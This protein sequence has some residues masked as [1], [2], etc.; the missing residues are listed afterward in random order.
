[1]T[2]GALARDQQK[3]SCDTKLTYGNQWADRLPDAFKVYPRAM[4]REATGSDLSAKAM[5]EY[6]Q[7]LLE[8]LREQ[9]RGRTCTLAEL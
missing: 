4:L 5:V 2:I 1:M 3:G 8:W 9:N 7:P 6:F